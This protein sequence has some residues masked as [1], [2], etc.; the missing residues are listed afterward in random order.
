MKNEKLKIKIK[1]RIKKK[2]IKRTERHFELHRN[3]SKS[4]R[5]RNIGNHT[6]RI[7]KTTIKK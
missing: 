1:K 5:P 6:Y 7:I 2:Q 4:I 3:D